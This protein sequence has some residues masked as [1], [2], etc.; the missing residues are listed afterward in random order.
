MTRYSS[1]EETAWAKCFCSSSGSGVVRWDSKRSTPSQVSM[2][3][4]TPQDFPAGAPS[5]SRICFI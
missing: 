5:S 3:E 4:I 2:E 1:P